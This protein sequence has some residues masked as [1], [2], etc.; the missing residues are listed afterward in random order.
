[1]TFSELGVGEKIL[2]AIEEL[3]FER[4]MPVQEAVLP[5]LFEKETDLIALAQTGTGKTAAFGIPTIQNLDYSNQNTEAVV[6][7]PTRELCVQI[8][9]DLT[10]YAKYIPECTVVPVYGGASIEV[11]KKALKKGAKIIV[12][13][14]GRINDLLRRKYIDLSNVKWAVLDEADEML[15]MGFKDDLDFI[16]A[17]T[18]DTKHTMLFSAT[19]PDEVARIAKNYM[20]DPKEVTIGVR[21]SGSANVRHCYYLVQAKDR[22]LALKRIADYY[23][24]IYAIIFCR[25]RSETQE[26]ATAL[27]RDGYNADALHGDLSQAQRDHVME[28]FRCRNLQ[29][30]VATDVAARGLDVSNLTHVIN[31]NL[32]DEIEQYTHR[33]GRTGR[34]DKTGISIAIIN[35]REKHKIKAIEKIIKK[36]F[37]QVPVPTGMDVCEKQFYNMIA[38]VERVEVKYDEINK[39]T[40]EVVKRLEWMDKKELIS[41]F[42]SVEFNRFLEYYKN[43]PDLNVKEKEEKQ[44]IDKKKSKVQHNDVGMARLFFNLGYADKI[45][46]QRLIGLINDTCDNKDIKIGKIDIMERFSYVDVDGYYANEIIEAFH[47]ETYKRKP[48]IVEAANARKAG[49]DKKSKK[50][51][52]S[53][54]V[55]T[56][57]KKEAKGDKKNKRKDRNKDTDFAP[58]KGRKGRSR[59]GENFF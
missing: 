22:Y 27:I 7:S 44:K 13:T 10:K 28:R 42:V 21:N 53:L 57:K 26:V 9:N 46:P 40:S 17:Q 33:S 20:N 19:M 24:S 25:T 23:P 3:G 41:R 31:Y 5:I 43:S 48:L 8:A 29:M 50:K 37:E 39:F 36:K 34:A 58:K 52:N 51:Q 54:P 49:A 16:L 14:P 59:R 35:L 1:M 2:K 11:Q 6:L 47:G 38:K 18:P 15:D 55:E 30:L 4:P 32:P 12:A 45:L 56:P